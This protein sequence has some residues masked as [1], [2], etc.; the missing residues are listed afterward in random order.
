MPTIASS[1][2]HCLTAEDV[3]RA[4][5]QVHERRRAFELKLTQQRL[6][7]ERAQREAEQKRLDE[8]KLIQQQQQQTTAAVPAS[9]A[10]PTMTP[11]QL[12]RFML[13]NE[14]TARMVLRG[15][16]E[17]R[18]QEFPEEFRVPTMSEIQRAVAAAY[19]VRVLDVISQRRTRAIVQPRQVS[20]MLCRMLT[21]NSLP[22]IGRI[23]GNRD[24]T[25]ALHA[26]ERL[27][28]LRDL[29]NGELTLADPLS[30]WIE[31]TIHHFPKT[32]IVSR[33]R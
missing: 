2:D 3:L 18:M 8:Q 5:R 15:I 4:A 32:N 33:N 11:E 21:V 14:D 1:D 22:R 12:L 6:D 26:F 19:N 17:A 31:R 27:G 16:S 9:D 23:H 7:R 25:T 30:K 10:L 28:W 24:H 13:A 20:M 29:L